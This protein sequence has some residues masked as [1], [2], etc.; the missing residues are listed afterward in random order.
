[1]PQHRLI[2]I[3]R[4]TTRDQDHER[5]GSTLPLGQGECPCYCDLSPRDR[6]AQLLLAVGRRGR[7]R[8]LRGSSLYLALKGKGEL[9][10]TLG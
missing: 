10:T 1:M 2:P 9:S 6:D 5:M 4:A 3:L 7:L 8:S